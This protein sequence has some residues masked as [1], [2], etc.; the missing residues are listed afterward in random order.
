MCYLAGAKKKSRVCGTEMARKL[1]IEEWG[2]AFW[3]T[4]HTVAWTHADEPNAQQRAQAHAFVSA[5]ARV[6]PCAACRQHFADMTSDELSRGPDADMFA[7]RDAFAR[8]T[9]AWHNAVNR[10]L[11]KPERSVEDVRIDYFDGRPRGG[12]SRGASGLAGL[13]LVVVLAVVLSR[14][15]PAASPRKPQRDDE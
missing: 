13:V 2:P 7:S 8:T 10:R 5:F 15:R 9:V 11:D 6:I 1:N 3:Q 14:A 4:L 12:W